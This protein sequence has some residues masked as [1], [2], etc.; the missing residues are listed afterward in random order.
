MRRGGGRTACGWRSGV[1]IASLDE[2][3][4]SRRYLWGLCALQGDELMKDRND[5][6]EDFSLGLPT[7]AYRYLSAILPCKQRL[8]FSVF[9]F[10]YFHPR[11]F[12]NSARILFTMAL[13][14]AVRRSSAVCHCFASISVREPAFIRRSA[15]AMAVPTSSQPEKAGNDIHVRVPFSHNSLAIETDKPI[16]R[17]L[18]PK[19]RPSH[20]FS[21]SRN[22]RRA[23]PIHG[24]DI[25]P[26]ATN[27]GEGRRM[28]HMGHRKQKIFGLHSRY[29]RQCSRSL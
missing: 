15:S 18:S 20:R 9:K 25:C 6:S 12:L 5:A 29:C 17:S 19:P 23:P 8:L 10:S 26:A 2:S 27:D 21:N 24:S 28:L 7:K 3:E 4:G 11:I 16:E 22:C 1:R 14:I 13:R